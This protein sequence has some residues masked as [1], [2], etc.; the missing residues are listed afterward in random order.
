MKDRIFLF[1]SVVLIILFVAGIVENILLLSLP[2][3]SGKGN[4]EQASLDAGMVEKPLQLQPK[5]KD[6]ILTRLEEAGLEPREA[7]YYR[8]ID[9]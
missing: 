1:I 9:E 4:S 8:V 7:R 5:L 2:S 3:L 6:D